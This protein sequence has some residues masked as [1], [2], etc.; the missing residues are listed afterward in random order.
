M[1]LSESCT[2]V[3]RDQMKNKSNKSD[4][5][6]EDDDDPAKLQKKRDWDEWKDGK[7]VN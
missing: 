1:S 7:S 4:D 5:E 3:T 2:A 6:S